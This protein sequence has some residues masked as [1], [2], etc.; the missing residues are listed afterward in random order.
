MPL[1]LFNTSKKICNKANIFPPSQKL[2]HHPRKFLVIFIHSRRHSRRETSRVNASESD[3]TL[4]SL[5][6]DESPSGAITAWCFT[7]TTIWSS[8]NREVH[9]AGSGTRARE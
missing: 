2:V 8:E 7:T 9:R 6:R 5:K 4:D 3:R 1:I